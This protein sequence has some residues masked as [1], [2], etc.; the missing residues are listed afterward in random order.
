MI[1]PMLLLAALVAAALSVQACVGSIAGAAIGTTGKVAG[2]AVGAVGHVAGSAV[3]MGHGA[4][5]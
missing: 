5:H 2:A 4:D 1:R 3:G